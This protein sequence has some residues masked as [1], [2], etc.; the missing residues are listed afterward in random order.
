MEDTKKGIHFTRKVSG[1]LRTGQV[2]ATTMSH[3]FVYLTIT[4]MNKLNIGLSNARRLL[5]QHR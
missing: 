4:Q 3:I 5:I 1:R 2:V